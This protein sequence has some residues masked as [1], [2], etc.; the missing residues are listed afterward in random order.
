MIDE[1]PYN[2]Y[3][4]Y[5]L[6]NALSQSGNINEA[7]Q[8]YTISIKSNPKYPFPKLDL[9]LIRINQ[10]KFN[11]AIT[12]LSEALLIAQKEQMISMEA[13]IYYG[14]GTA[15]AN[16]RDFQ[17]AMMFADQ[18]LQRQPQYH[19]ALLLKQKIQSLSGD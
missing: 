14:L 17:K 1:Y 5:L 6:A 10:G 19:D 12:I 9:G 2:F 4:H 13:T 3:A 11:E 8:H 15:Y 7:I 18:A 16:K